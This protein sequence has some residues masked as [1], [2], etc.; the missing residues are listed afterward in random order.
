M[1]YGSGSGDACN[2]A[3]EVGIVLVFIVSLE[4]RETLGK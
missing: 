4:V 3:G 1:C 2:C